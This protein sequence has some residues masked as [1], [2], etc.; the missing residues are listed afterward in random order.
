MEPRDRTARTTALTLIRD[1]ISER[2]GIYFDHRSLDLMMDKISDLMVQGDF[3]SPIDFYYLLKYGGESSGEWLNLLNAISVRE[4]Y[5]WRE[6][7]QIQALVSLLLPHFSQTYREPL[8]IWSAACATGE[9]PI[10]IAIALHQAGWFDRI[11]IEIY[12]SDVSPAAICAAQRGFYKERA[13]RSLPSALRERYF[14]E[15]SGGWEILPEIHSR[16]AWRRAN[17]TNKPEI[18]DFARSNVIFCRNVFIYF[19][20]TV[21]RN[22]V[23]MFA[24]YM[25]AP[26]YLFLGAAE[27]LLKFTTDFRLQEL[28]P[29]FVYLK[30]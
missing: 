20:D 18:A 12:A 21:I 9:E 6:M 1:L 4:T 29:A 2:T 16:I 11:P 25:P 24:E 28:G 5:F 7:D 27:S 17:L 3:D 22:V 14:T 30:E 19:S 8:R 13:F 26:G 15:K 10:T 23:S